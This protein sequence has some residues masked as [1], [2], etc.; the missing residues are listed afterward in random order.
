MLVDFRAKCAKVGRSRPAYDWTRVERII[1][2]ATVA[3]KGGRAEMFDYFDFRERLKKKRIPSPEITR[4][5]GILV[6]KTKGTED[7]DLE[8]E[9]PDFPERC[10]YNV[11]AFREW[12]LEATEENRVI[13]GGRNLTGQA[14]DKL[15]AEV[16]EMLASGHD[17]FSNAVFAKVGGAFVSSQGSGDG[18]TAFS[19]HPHCSLAFGVNFGASGSSRPRPAL[20]KKRGDAAALEMGSLADKDSGIPHS[21]SPGAGGGNLD[22]S[23]LRFHDCLKQ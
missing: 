19:G 22:T 20:G 11:V 13:Q 2:A 17:G 16:P 18:C 14:A 1:R 3:R 10:A 12:F 15:L 7:Q 8:G 5:W 21:G 6:E 4:R 23:R 9:N